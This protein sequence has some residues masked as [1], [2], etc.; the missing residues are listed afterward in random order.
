MEIIKK[1]IGCFA[2]LFEVSD[3]FCPTICNTL[4]SRPSVEIFHSSNLVGELRTPHNQGYQLHK[5]KISKDLKREKY[6]IE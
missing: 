3:G 6:E 1:R 4:S 5:G 2:L